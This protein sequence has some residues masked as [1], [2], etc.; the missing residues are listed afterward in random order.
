MPAK[1]NPVPPPTATTGTTESPP[2]GALNTPGDDAE[3]QPKASHPTKGRRYR[4]LGKGEGDYC[5]YQ[6]AP[7][8]SD[9]P[10]GALVPIPDVPRFESTAEAM[11]WLR[12]DSG[13]KLAGKQVMVFQAMEICTINVVSKPSVSIEKKPKIQ[14]SGPE[15]EEGEA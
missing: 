1:T 5:I 9:L 7:D 8:G 2:P 12:M 15:T 14:V 4:V 10:K 6:I 3:A 11:R 13:D